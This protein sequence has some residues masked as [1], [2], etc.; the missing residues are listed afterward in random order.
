MARTEQKVRSLSAADLGVEFDTGR[1]T[2]PEV[3]VTENG[4]EQ[5]RGALS[6]FFDDNT[7]FGPEERD[8]LTEELN[9]TGSFNVGGGAAPLFTIEK[10]A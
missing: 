4:I 7:E 10:V 8:S 1:V 9:A 2:S 5:W 3:R 6:D